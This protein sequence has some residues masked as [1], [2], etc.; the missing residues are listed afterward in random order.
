MTNEQGKLFLDEVRAIYKECS[1]LETPERAAKVTAFSILVML[2]GSGEH[3][4]VDYR[5][6][7]KDFELVDFFH[8]DFC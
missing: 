3:I 5:V 6:L 7:T 8:H 1:K 4:G 2:D